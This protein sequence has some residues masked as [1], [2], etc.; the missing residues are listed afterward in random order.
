M[1]VSE[2]FGAFSHRGTGKLSHFTGR[3]TRRS[4]FFVVSSVSS[5]HNHDPSDNV[6]EVHRYPYAPWIVT[7]LSP[8]ATVDVACTTKLRHSF[9]VIAFA[10]AHE[11]TSVYGGFL[12]AGRPN[13]TNRTMPTITTT[14]TSIS[15][16]YFS[17]ND[18]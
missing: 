16:Q 8:S 4:F 2:H 9:P 10:S 15:I 17:K 18:L 7:S 3:T 5:S 13:I 6:F 12:S 14:P 1:F 11:S